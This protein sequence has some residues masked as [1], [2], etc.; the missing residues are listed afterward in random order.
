MD[1]LLA[2]ADAK[3]SDGATCAGFVLQEAWRNAAES[4]VHRRASAV[5]IRW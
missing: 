2:V 1:F 3:V 5:K 4:L